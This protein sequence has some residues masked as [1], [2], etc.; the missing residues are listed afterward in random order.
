MIREST[1]V[2]RCLSKMASELKKDRFEKSSLDS[3]IFSPYQLLRR[4]S[5]NE[6]KSF[7]AFFW[8]FSF[9]SSLFFFAA[10]WPPRC[11]WGRR[12]CRRRR[13]RRRRCCSRRRFFVEL[14]PLLRCDKRLFRKFL[15]FQGGRG[16]KGI[17]RG[18]CWPPGF[19]W[20]LESIFK[21]EKI[22]NQSEMKSSLYL[23]CCSGLRIGH[24]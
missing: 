13:R 24:K 8:S 3:S 10:N 16:R 7:S 15:K 5:E 20:E 12:H 17:V 2:P 23:S 19:I 11:C 6:K 1:K 18:L 4:P 22:A 21:A 9:F 14:Q